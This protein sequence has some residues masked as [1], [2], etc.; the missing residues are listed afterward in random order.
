MPVGYLNSN[1]WQKLNDLFAISRHF[2]IFADESDSPCRLRQQAARF[3]LSEHE[4]NN[5]RR[6]ETMDENE[7]RETL[8]RLEA[9][10]WE[11]T[12][13]RKLPKNSRKLPE[14]RQKLPKNSPLGA[15]LYGKLPKTLRRWKFFSIA[16]FIAVPLHRHS[17]QK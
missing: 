5:K 3:F 14:K 17:R 11:P 2:C 8:A 10:G 4:I 1:P 12:P 15:K 16:F 6:N 9:A 13:S 7:L